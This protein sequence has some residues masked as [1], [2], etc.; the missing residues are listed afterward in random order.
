LDQCHTRFPTE[1][2]SYHSPKINPA[3]YQ[4]INWKK[5]AD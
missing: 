3:I 4:R 5:S 2:A 1:L